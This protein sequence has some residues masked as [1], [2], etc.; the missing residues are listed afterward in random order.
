MLHLR[1]PVRAL[2]AIRGV[3][4]GQFLSAEQVSLDLS[5]AFR[6]TPTARFL[7]GEN[8]QWW[9]PNVA[10][11]R[12]MVETAGFRIER[13]T[14]AYAIPLGAGHPSRGRREGV[15]ARML[16]RLLAGGSGVPHAAVLARPDDGG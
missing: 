15:R 12:S 3:C 8:C 1:D 16:A 7:R 5:A 4:A 11:H 9:V 13:A 10:G 6:R 2:E 14:G